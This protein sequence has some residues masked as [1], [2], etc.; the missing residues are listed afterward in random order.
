MARSVGPKIISVFAS[1]K[2]VIR[3]NV[4]VFGMVGELLAQC[5]STAFKLVI[6][7]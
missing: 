4:F 3:V 2:L 1:H 6:N 7:M 5:L